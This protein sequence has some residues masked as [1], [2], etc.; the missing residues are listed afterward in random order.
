LVFSSLVFLY[1]FLPLTLLIY[2]L[3]PRQLKNM[4]LF[5]V[6]L[7]FYGWGEPIYILLM[8]FSTLVDYSLGILVDKYRDNK[9][10]SRLFVAASVF[11]N[12]G[13]LG[14][15]KYADWFLMTLNSVLGC[16]ISLSNLRL[17]IGI[18]FYTFQTMSYSIDV[19]RG[20]APVQKNFVS[21]GAF[22]SL[23]PQLIAGPIVRYQDI[24]SELDNRI[25]TI[26]LFGEGVERFVIGLGK[27]VLFANNIGMLFELISDSSN[28][29]SV[30]GSWLGVIAYALQIYFDFSG[31]SD[32]A[33]GLGRMFGF[34]FPENF[35]YPFIAQSVTEFWRRWHI[36]LGNWFRD[37]VYIPLGGNRKGEGITYRN[38]FVVWTL[39][40]LW[41]GAS[42]N[43]VLWGIYFAVILMLEKAGLDRLLSRSPRLLRHVYTLTALAISWVLF[44]FE[45]LTQVLRY[46]RAMFGIGSARLYVPSDLYFLS[47]YAFLLAVLFLASTPLPTRVMN[48][49]LKGDGE[50]VAPIL[51][52]V[53][54]VAL[55]CVCTAYLVD[56][57][58]NPFLYFRF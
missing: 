6:S 4:T 37:Y 55:L 14:V 53:F 48:R 43:F 10:T 5:L 22:V 46:L 40:G 20:D 2:W 58:Y 33:V 7:V 13:L 21:M 36:T 34:H 39:T 28:E 3:S 8:L 45:D 56:A 49:F 42:W 30:L 41:H 31:Y 12:L 32:M 16:S 11:I 29:I 18:S 26:D 47:N 38:L 57:S 24:A 50:G 15:F 17:P 25:E 54:M 51:S 1:T 44:A 23:F 35:R 27:K 52:S 9:K 19:Y